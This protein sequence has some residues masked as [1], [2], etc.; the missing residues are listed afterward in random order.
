MAEDG[1]SPSDLLFRH[2]VQ[3]R[4]QSLF[5]PGQ[6]VLDVGCGTGADAL[7]LAA[8]GLRVVGIDPLPAA[9]AEA[10]RRAAHL[11]LEGEGC[12]FELAH[13]EEASSVGGPFDGAYSNFGALNHAD[14]R[15]VGLALARALRPEAPVLLSLRGPWPLPAV[16]RR[17]LT[18]EGARRR[19]RP[20][21]GAVPLGSLA[22]PTVREAQRALGPAFRWTGVSA[23]GVLLPASGPGR[24]AADHPQAFGVFAALERGV[25]GWPVLRHLGDHVVLEGRRSQAR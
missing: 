9:I 8:R 19:E 12:R 24:W 1:T 17:A 25:R 4:L 7:F 2:V 20:S 6:R 23:L 22:Y 18:A 14:L 5:Q 15:A 13:A 10:R 16:L 3:G 21:P 11:G